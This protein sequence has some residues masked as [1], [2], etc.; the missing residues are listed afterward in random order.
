[1]NVKTRISLAVGNICFANRIEMENSVQTVPLY[2]SRL[3][4]QQTYSTKI[5]C[6]IGAGY[7]LE[8]KK[9]NSVSSYQ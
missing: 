8:K 5:D 9:E 7:E 1:M 2:Q 6:V 3:T 4:Q